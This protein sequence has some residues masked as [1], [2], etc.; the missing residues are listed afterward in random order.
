MMRFTIP[1]VFI[2]ATALYAY[3]QPANDVCD[4]AIIIDDLTL[5][6]SEP[7]QFTTAGAT[8][9]GYGPATCF[10]ASETDVWFSFTA[11]ATTVV[12]SVLGQGNGANTLA[13]PQIALYGG[14]CGGTINE[15]RCDSDITFS[16]VAEV[17]R[18]GLTIGEE[19]L[20]RVSGANDAEG[21]FQ[22]CLNNFNPPVAPGQDCITGS[23]LCDKSPFS[24]EALTGTGLDNDEAAGSCL[25]EIGSSEQQ[26]TWFKWTAATAGSLTFSISPNNPTDDL[27][28]ALYELPN[29]I[30][31]CS[32]KILLRCNAT[33]TG[34]ATVTGID[35]T[36]TDDTENFNC[37]P[38]EDGF[39]RFI[40]MV[41]GASYGLIINNFSTSGQGFAIEW[42]GEG[43]F[44]GPEADFLITPDEG[45]RCEEDFI[46]ED[47]STFA[48]GT[49]LS[50]TWNFGEDARPETAT[51]PGPHNV[52]YGSIG[53]KF[54][55]LT[56]E[57]SQ[58]CQVS[59]VRSLEA[60]PC[61]EDLEALV[62]EVE[63]T[64]NPCPG[65]EEG[66]ILLG[67]SGGT[68][69]YEFRRSDQDRFR[70]LVRFVDLASGEY[71]IIARDARGC[72]DTII[73][74]VTEPERIVVNA[75]ADRSLDLGGSLEVQAFVTPP[76]DY[77]IRWCP[78]E[79]VSD[80]SALSVTI[81]P[82]GTTEYILKATS[83][84]GCGA[85]DTVLYTVSD[86]RPFYMPNVFSP[87]G[88]GVN[89]TFVGYAGVAV[90]RIQNLAVYDRWGNQVYEAE[91][92][93]VGSEANG[94]DGFFK[95]QPA[96]I[97]VYVAVA[98]VR[99]INDQVITFS[100]D[101]TLIR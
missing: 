89:D 27:D 12:T 26:S 98:Q 78:P 90:D 62:A 14:V 76:G 36:S 91:E 4:N 10:R 9:S 95:G 19:Y 66:V 8:N 60:L 44:L 24:V 56:L 96:P 55:V 75:G 57:T 86:E 35:L 2:C 84:G 67:A 33:A 16:G 82:P 74:E 52:I 7:A 37:D 49:I 46:V 64:D 59:E 80:S 17:V 20:I 100:T 29:G 30:D 51:G 79:G 1:L 77:E 94:W 99:F 70:E 72:L 21:T 85:A 71:E 48:N 15:L 43:T 25:G 61:C 28:F 6:C 31:D 53:T 50:W 42:G 5:F 97:G 22:L 11:F 47:Q 38:G 69:E 68:P 58:G 3:A 101:L 83:P 40:D 41:E 92:L 32:G 93:P 18:G 87:N 54:V 73:A 34:C 81:T 45:L 63:I 39:V 13:M 65:D 23:V 88:D